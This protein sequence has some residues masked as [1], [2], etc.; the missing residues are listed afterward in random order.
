MEARKMS[1]ESFNKLMNIE[2]VENAIG[3]GEEWP[4]P[5]NY[6]TWLDCW[7]K[8]SH[9]KAVECL[10]CGSKEDLVGAHVIVSPSDYSNNTKVYLTILCKGCN[11]ITEPFDVFKN[12]LVDVS[13]ICPF[14]DIKKYY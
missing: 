1:M 13:D 2:M 10:L 12:D 8:R 3:S 5:V 9:K 4:K 7:E 14:S 11:K 6:D